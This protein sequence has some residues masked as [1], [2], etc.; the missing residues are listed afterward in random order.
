MT[1]PSPALPPRALP[2]S[3]DLMRNLLVHTAKLPG[4]DFRVLTYYVT[5]APLGETVRE[6]AKTVSEAVEIS[7]GSTSKSIGRLV[8][9]GWLAPAFRV[10]TVPFYR[11]GDRVL[12][13]AAA[14][15]EG[16][17]EQHLA[18]VSHLPVRGFGSE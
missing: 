9:D 14:A 12:E 4:A 1:S 2:L 10:G 11:A 3:A 8:A 6:T 16:Q 18:T 5:A 13:L 15:F 7:R 17:A